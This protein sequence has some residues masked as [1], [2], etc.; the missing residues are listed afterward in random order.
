MSS[1]HEALQMMELRGGLVE[2]EVR[3]KRPDLLNLY[4][5]Y[6]NESLAA[7]RLLDTDLKQLKPG[8]KILEIGGGVL[9]LAVQLA[10]EGFQVTSVEPAG[11][12]FEEIPFLMQL[13]SN[14]DKK[15]ENLQVI[16]LPIEE[17]EFKSQFNYIFSINVMEH[18]HDP[19]V[20]A[21]NIVNYLDEGAKYRF[22]C[23]NYNFPY[24]PH[25]SK[26]IFSRKNE[27]FFLKIENARNSSLREQDIE[28]LYR[29]LNFITFSKFNTEVKKA[30]V[31][32]KANQLAFFEIVTRALQDNSLS[33]RHPGLIR[34]VKI[35]DRFGMLNVFKI[36]PVHFQPIMDVEVY[37][38]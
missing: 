26:W 34:L 38:S 7:R 33:Q 37:K 22:F 20:V 28:G 32:V 8:S 2:K 15:L 4:L 36:I 31:R 30:N 25:F 3:D 18:L 21:M 16:T 1:I 10:N 9:A 19:Y 13:Y 12:G 5:T 6:Q 27:A 24:E 11:N 17:C 35:L 23:P 14:L 29:S